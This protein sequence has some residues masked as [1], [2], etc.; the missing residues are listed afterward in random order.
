[1]IKKYLILCATL[2]CSSLQSQPKQE[3]KSSLLLASAINKI[4]Q[5]LDSNASVG[6]KVVSLKTN[7]C[8]YQKNQDHLFI[9][10][11]NTKLITAAAALEILGP[12]FRFETQLVTDAQ[13]TPLKIGNLYIKGGGDPTLETAHLE[14]S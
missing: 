1:M 8:L 12:D 10:A 4:V 7:K 14:E 13:S 11:S 3:P 2:Q 6:I 5:S 9:P